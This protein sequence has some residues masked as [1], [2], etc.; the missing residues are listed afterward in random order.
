MICGAVRKNH[1]PPP[2]L[3]PSPLEKDFF[4]KRN[5]NIYSPS[6]FF[7]PFSQFSFLNYFPSVHLFSF[8]FTFSRFISSPDILIRKKKVTRCWVSF[9]AYSTRYLYEVCAPMVQYI[10]QQIFLNKLSQCFAIRS[11]NF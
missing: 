1:I 11:Q 8:S 10:C 7:V 4:F 5:A 3:P 6:I 2:P 9:S